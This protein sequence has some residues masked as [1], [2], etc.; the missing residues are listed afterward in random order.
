M[1]TLTFWQGHSICQ[2]YLSTQL[3]HEP[4]AP[5]EH[6]LGRRCRARAATSP[7]NDN[8]PRV[9]PPKYSISKHFLQ[10]MWL[11]SSIIYQVSKVS[12]A[13]STFVTTS[14]KCPRHGC[15]SCVCGF[16]EDACKLQRAVP[17]WKGMDPYIESEQSISTR[18]SLDRATLFEESSEV[19]V[20]CLLKHGLEK[21]TRLM[22]FCLNDCMQHGLD[23]LQKF[24]ALEIVLQKAWVCNCPACEVSCSEELPWTLSTKGVSSDHCEYWSQNGKITA[25]T[26]TCTDSLNVASTLV[27]NWLRRQS[28]LLSLVM[29]VESFMQADSFSAGPPGWT[30]QRAS[31][32]S[33]TLMCSSAITLTQDVCSPFEYSLYLAQKGSKRKGP[34]QLSMHTKNLARTESSRNNSSSG[35]GLLFLSQL[36][37]YLTSLASP[38]HAQ[39]CPWGAK[40]IGHGSNSSK[41][42]KT[43]LKWCTKLH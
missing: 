5:P 32:D 38:S 25:A 12:S 18:Q 40:K 7:G 31:H 27:S 9:P 1:T 10:G 34:T 8:F 37:L 24:V 6:V 33:R 4:E 13:D 35:T 11:V 22:R 42:G 3:W 16:S 30:V 21:K 15:C 43:Q 14:K 19:K 39:P 29:A 28:H 17:S 20:I 26:G 23:I 36:S 41:H 2:T